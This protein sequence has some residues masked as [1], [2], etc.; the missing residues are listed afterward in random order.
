M[1]GLTSCPEL[2]MCNLGLIIRKTEMETSHVPEIL[3]FKGPPEPKIL[4]FLEFESLKT[5]TELIEFESGLDRDILGLSPLTILADRDETKNNSAVVASVESGVFA[6]NGC[7]GREAR[8]TEWFASVFSVMDRAIQDLDTVFLLELNLAILRMKF[9][10]DS[11]VGYFNERKLLRLLD[12]MRSSEVDKTL[13]I[14][15]GGNDRSLGWS[16]GGVHGFVEVKGCY[17]LGLFVVLLD[18]VANG[19]KVEFAGAAEVAGVC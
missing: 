13:V 11:I 9:D 12:F 15:S 1:S 10:A 7:N 14:P 19:D 3:S 4:D 16:F 2:H 17:G 5:K 18:V 8:V 6:G